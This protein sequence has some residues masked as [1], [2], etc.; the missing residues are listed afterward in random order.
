MHWSLLWIGYLATWATIPHILLRNKPPASTLAWVWAVILFPY[1][2][3]I[4]YFVFGTD[5]LVRQK[6]RAT[7]EMDASGG[8][9]ERRVSA[10][11]EASLEH[12]T[13][14]ERQ[15]AKLLLHLHEY[16]ISCAE[17]TRLLVDGGAFFAALGN[18]SR[19]RGIM[20]I[21]NFTSGRTIRGRM[22]CST[23]SP[24]LPVEA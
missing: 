22:K 16:A 10:D 17:E 23:A 14:Q 8:R 2:G 19:K 12:L 13:P 4:F 6:L 7:R 15:H 21:S 9:A 3:T 24:P 18:G 20:C 5:R 1:A 11:T